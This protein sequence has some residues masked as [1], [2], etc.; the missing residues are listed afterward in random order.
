MDPGAP[1]AVVLRTG[2]AVLHDVNG[3]AQNARVADGSSRHT[4]WQR[5][6]RKDVAAGDSRYQGEHWDSDESAREGY[7]SHEGKC[8]SLAEP[9]NELGAGKPCI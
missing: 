7:A 5:H 4:A 9:F 6:D 1:A 2:D 8:R 3:H